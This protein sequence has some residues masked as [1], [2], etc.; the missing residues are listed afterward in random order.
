M[1]LEVTPV[2][3]YQQMYLT[4]FR[5]SEQAVNI[6]IEAQRKCEELYLSS[7]EASIKL[8]LPKNKEGE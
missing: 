8:L 1:F 7:P 4:L 2:P 5:A 3:D 6:L